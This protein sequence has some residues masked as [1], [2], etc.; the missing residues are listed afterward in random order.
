[1]FFSFIACFLLLIRGHISA[2]RVHGSI[3]GGS[4]AGFEFSRPA[5]STEPRLLLRRA[6]ELTHYR[7]R[8]SPSHCTRDSDVVLR[9]SPAAAAEVASP[10]HIAHNVL[11]NKNDR[12]A[13]IPFT[14]RIAMTENAKQSP[15]PDLAAGVAIADIAD[16]AMLQGHVGDEAVLLAR[17]GDE[18]FAV[19]AQCTHY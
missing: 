3:R 7:R 11:R 14:R 1:M 17:R 6:G 8:S 18:L 9:T 16:G 12:P 13:P 15:G 19:G 2:G 10:T 5:K 4:D